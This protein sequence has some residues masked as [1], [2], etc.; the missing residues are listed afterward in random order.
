MLRKLFAC[1]AIA[2]GV[3]IATP[4]FAQQAK[5]TL[6]VDLPG[7]AA[8][9]DPHLQADTDSYSVYRNIFDNL[10]TRDV[11][12]EIAPQVAKAWRYVDDVTIEFDIQEG[13][14]FHNGTPLTPED[15]AFSINRISSKEF[16]SSQ[17]TWFDKI[18][19][20]QA[21]DGKV[22]VKTSEPYPALLAQLVNLSIV[23]K[24][25]VE[26]KGNQAFNTSPVGSG[27]FKFVAWQTGSQIELAANDDYWRGDVPFRSVVY[28]VVP[29]VATRIANLQ[30][31]RSD[32]TRRLLPDEAR[33]VENDPNLKTLAVATERISFM[34]INALAGPTKDLRV[35]KAIAHAVDKPAIIEALTEGYGKPVN[36]DLAPPVFGY[37]DEVAGYD[38][39]PELAKKLVTE[40]GAEGATLEFL[41]S[42]VFDRRIA[43][44]VQQM[45]GDVGLK[46]EITMLDHPTFLRRRQGN[47]EE[48]GSL[49]LGRWS[50]ACQDADGVLYARYRSG[51]VWSKWTNTAFDTE[52]DAAR[53]IIDPATRLAHYKRALEIMREDVPSQGLFQDFA[54][55]GARKELQW[56]PTPNEAFFIFDMKW[57]A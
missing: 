6:F 20:A 33:Q 51:T 29:D 31:G 32:V 35:R 17:R 1:A 49:A 22:T 54:I 28:R 57:G 45:L 13:I 53:R 26:A 42:P 19:S 3:A 48:S 52:V 18:A 38:Y 8:T 27:P 36:V 46:V 12:G 21:G 10:V 4:A 44:A 56:T 47:P 2:A 43:E 14:T 16:G 11:Q 30:T 50:C 23:P 24:A 5:E 25:V 7:D 9:L 34:F 37:N 55:Y 41:M 15:V 39:D 40:A